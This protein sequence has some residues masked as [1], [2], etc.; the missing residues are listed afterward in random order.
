MTDSTLSGSI[1]TG[2]SN[3]DSILLGGL[4]NPSIN[5]DY[6]LSGNDPSN[7][8]SQDY[9]LQGNVNLTGATTD[10]QVQGATIVATAGSPYWGIIAGS[11]ITLGT[12]GNVVII[13]SS[14]AGGGN[15]LGIR[16][17][18]YITS[19]TSGDV[20]TIDGSQIGTKS[21]TTLVNSYAGTNFTLINNLST[22]VTNEGGTKADITLL[23]S[24]IGTTAKF[25]DLQAYV[26]TTA[27]KVTLDD[28]IGTTAKF[29]D[30]Q[31][32]VGTNTTLISNLSTR[33]TNE[34]GTK[35]DTFG[36]V[37]GNNIS[38]GTAGRN[39]TVNY[40]GPTSGASLGLAAGTGVSLGTSGSVV[41]VTATV[42]THEVFVTTGNGFG[43]ASLG[44][45]IRR[46]STTIKNVGDAIQYTDAVGTGASFKIN[47][48]GV[49]GITYTDT[50]ASAT[51]GFIG[52]SRNSNQLTTAV[53]SMTAADRLIYTA[54]STQ[55]GS[56]Q[57]IPGSV[58]F[59]TGL[60]QG[61]LIYP[62]TNTFPNP[63]TS[64]MTSFRITKISNL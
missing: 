64:T 27:S 30:L 59:I 7:S 14:S 38:V 11:N 35:A 49:Y 6:I 57:S 53:Q 3:G 46:F 40:T 1:T 54:M 47:H 37:A 39:Y 33:V 22:R 55:T 58:S 24:Y 41:T 56:P 63:G 28:Y 19:S 31:N 25:S 23:N 9:I 16:T 50:T 10:S 12:I 45:S 62:H 61:D 15:P 4:S 34:G 43:A 36:L 2:N 20:V 51:G 17:T 48:S 44:T 18:N 29:S 5:G 8:T 13:T 52:V 21:D 26:G 42:G 60:N 32:Y